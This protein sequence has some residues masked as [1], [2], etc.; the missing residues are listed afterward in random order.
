M[1]ICGRV[2]T[3]YTT[4]NYLLYTLMARGKQWKAL[5]EKVDITEKHDI[6]EA[7]K[8]VKELSYSKFVWSCELHIKTSANPKYNDQLVRGTIVLPNWTGKTVRVAAFV[9]DDKR[10][11]AT[12]AGADLVG[13]AELIEAIEKG[14]ID[15]DVMVTSGDM[16]RDLAKV[17]KQLWP[18]GLMPSPKAGTVSSNI[19]QTIDEIKKWR[20]EF[21]LDKTG[22]IHVVI[23]KMDFADEALVENY[24]AILKAITEAKPSG[25]KGKLILKSVIAPTMWP[26][27]Q[28]A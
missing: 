20:V 11:D 14:T 18:K 27:V 12:K 21:K 3:R 2:F 8:L 19:T 10:D 25:I 15:F 16:M 26:G 28:V 23:G 17:A 4:F 13:N 9:S 22:N 6:V 24:N 1:A 7:V 5:K